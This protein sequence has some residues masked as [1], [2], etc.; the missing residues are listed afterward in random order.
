[1]HIFT[2][3]N[4]LPAKLKNA[5][6][7][8]GNFDGVHRA[9]QQL[10]ATAR[11]LAKAQEKPFGVLTFEP[12]PRALF[13]PDLPAFRITTPA[14]KAK[15]ITLANADLL[16]MQNFDWDFAALSAQDF[17][18]HIL[19]R[20]LGA[21]HVVVGYDFK[22]GQFRK[23]EPDLIKS[24]G[25]PLTILEEIADEGESEISS[26]KIRQALR[27]GDIAKANDV[28]GWEWEISGTVIKGDQRGRTLGY[29]TANFPLGDVVH[30]AYGVYAARVQIEGEDLWRPAA[31]NIGIRPM[32]ETK[33]AQVESFIFDFNQDIYD[34]ILTVRPVKHLR[35]EAKFSGLEL[36]IAQMDKDCL[37]A[38]QILEA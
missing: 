5:V 6:I 29:P 32:F 20:D 28:L 16:I 4:Q 10:L 22:F 15:R 3:S 13:Q 26:S 38:R 25:I 11:A 9:H 19:I 36:L 17:I 7:A 18:D 12:H 14:L 37:L 1:M 34:K 8:I 23:G 30:P 2:A 24:S 33:T 27:Q 31:I 21:S 35:S